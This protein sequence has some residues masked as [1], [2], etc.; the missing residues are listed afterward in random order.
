MNDAL[1]NSFPPF[2]EE[3]SLR[4]A[5]ESV[6]AEFGSVKSLVILPAVR[7]PKNLQCACFLRL[8]SASAES[9]MRS[10]LNVISFDDDLGFFADVD[11]TWAGQTI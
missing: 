1:N 8:E 11:E 3:Q 10:K 9:A 4:S 6:C 7:G 2:P 5:I